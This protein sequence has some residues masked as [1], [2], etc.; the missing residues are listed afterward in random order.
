MYIY[1]IMNKGLYI[2]LIV[3]IFSITGKVNGQTIN[4]LN[5]Y[6]TYNY[7]NDDFNS[8]VQIWGGT[9]LIDGSFVFGNDRKIIHFDGENWSHIPT[10][11]RDSLIQDDNKVFSI[12]KSK[13]STVYVGRN[14]MFGKL[15][16][17]SIGQV[18]F[19]P[20]IKDSSFTNIW[21]IYET[22][23]ENIIFTS[24]ESVVFY[25]PKTGGKTIHNLS[26]D[27]NRAY[28]ESSVQVENGILITFSKEVKINTPKEKLLYYFS[29]RH[30]SFSKVDAE[31]NVKA[32]YNINNNW[33]VVDYLGAVYSFDVKTK[34]INKTHSLKYKNEEIHVNQILLRN[35]LLWV[36][37]EKYGVVIF[38][39]D[40]RSLRSLSG[41][42]GLQ[43]NNV[44]RM[45]FDN[46]SNLWLSLDNGVSVISLNPTMSIWSRKEGIEGAIESFVSY[47]DT[48]FMIA[49]RS[50][51]FKSKIEDDKLVFFNTQSIAE[52]T[53][54]IKRFNTE[55]GERLVVVGYNGIY[56]VTEGGAHPI[57]MAL[58]LYGWELHPSPFK[59]NQLFIGG[60]DFIGLFTYLGD[61][62]WSFEK[63]KETSADIIK[64]IYHK[65]RLYFS[66]KGE[67]IF[68]IDKNNEIKQIPLEKTVDITVSHFYLENHQGNVY[69]GY[70]KGLLKLD[71]KENRFKKVEI[72]MLKTTDFDLNFHRLY[73]HPFKNELL[74]V[75]FNE[76]PNNE[77]KHVGYIEVQNDKYIWH[78][79]E[80]TA[81]MK[82]IIYDISANEEYVF[83]GMNTGFAALNR[84]HLEET[85][86]P[87]QVYISKVALNDRYVL[88]NVDYSNHLDPIK[89]GK[90]IRFDIRSSQY[91]GNDNIHYRFRLKGISDQWSAFEKNSYKIYDQLPAGEYTVE[92]QGINQY[93]IKSEVS[94]YTFTILPPWY[95]TWWAYTLYVLVFIV[96]VY[97]VT[98]V[99]IYR[100]RQKN[101]SLELI[102]SERT[103]EIAEKNETLQ[104]QKSEI[105]EINT[106]LLGS[107]N[108]A[109][110]IQNTILPSKTSLDNLFDDYF[111]FYLPKD[112]VSGDFYWAQ[113]FDKT[114]I[115]SAID[116]T[117]HG[118]P[119][120]FVSIV[121][122]NTLI[123]A[124]KEFGLRKPADILD[125]QRE[126]VI[127]TFKNEGHQDVKDGMDLALVSLDTDTLE[128]EYAGANNSLIIVRNK[129]IIEIKADKQPIGEFVKMSPFTNHKIALQKGDCIYLYT[130]GFVDQFG[131]KKNKK[132]KSKPFKE[133][134][135]NISQLPMQE[136]NKILQKTLN[137]WR[138]EHNQVDDICIF[139]VKV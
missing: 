86:K 49:S 14:R 88:Y 10:I 33:Y 135:S 60:E 104:Q 18:L 11:K 7:T 25:N 12:F 109:K 94:S 16:Y 57:T 129:E 108:Y 132:F 26:S 82:G 67:G 115:W 43:D 80:V 23:D 44:F 87:W 107:I 50:G 90:S 95:L 75:V 32:S 138:G 56:D 19:K 119:G 48:S 55:F 70:N 9:Q 98:L 121:G 105:S 99:S 5:K 89:H 102:V 114:I 97:L 47:G 79:F 126:L 68:T 137:D 73:S 40:G 27:K 64:F 76:S 34:I 29:F 39:L 127:D 31:V 63:I 133:L 122:N 6:L 61:K 84:M 59:K 15:V 52:A 139:G 120:A 118:V 30:L 22:A 92:F 85:K 21:S 91:F 100:V 128:L 4:Q 54:D 37:T 13:N 112:I 45:F 62:N 117:G 42:D 69:A 96:I 66:V 38:D 72:P 113:K 101:K 125:K 35:N 28:I 20:I 130:D 71:I 74:A 110:R 111:V 36:A 78:P 136:Q 123:R 134:L 93:A 53:Y 83:F 65:D 17:D 46:S 103:K 2:I 8:T 106:D 131:G 3:F 51:V 1:T 58:S 124:T 81:L 41:N 24:S 116:C 77:S